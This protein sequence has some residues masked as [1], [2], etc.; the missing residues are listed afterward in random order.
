MYAIRRFRLRPQ[1]IVFPT[2][3]WGVFNDDGP[4][5]V[6]YATLVIDGRVVGTVD[7]SAAFQAGKRVL[8]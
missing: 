2:T 6:S 5:A 8:T 3:D 4:I 1:K 7:L